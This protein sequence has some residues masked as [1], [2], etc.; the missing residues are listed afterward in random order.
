M[1]GCIMPVESIKLLQVCELQTCC[2]LIFADMLQVDE[3]TCIK[4]ACSSQL[5]ASL[6]TTCKRLRPC[7]HDAATK[8]C[9]HKMNTVCNCSHDA[10][11]MSVSNFTLITVD[12]IYHSQNV[13]SNRNETL[14]VTCSHS[15]ETVEFRYGQILSSLSS[16]RGERCKRILISAW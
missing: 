5:A 9:R 13:S 15:A 8:L 12:N 10:R 16:S 4:P 14:T 6:L 1:P 2:N 11:S 3:T 7:S